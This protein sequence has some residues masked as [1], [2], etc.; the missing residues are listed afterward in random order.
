MLISEKHCN[1]HCRILPPRCKPIVLQLKFP[2]LTGGESSLTLLRRPPLFVVR[3]VHK[4]MQLFLRLFASVSVVFLQLTYE[5][6]RITLDLIHII[7]RKLSPLLTDAALHLASFTFQNIFI[8]SYPHLGE[9]R[10]KFPFFAAHGWP[11]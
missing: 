5:F 10:S 6:F 8:H 4:I 11:R 1:F 3:A 2:S 7:V 9:Y